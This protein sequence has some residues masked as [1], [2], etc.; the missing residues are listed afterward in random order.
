MPLNSIFLVTTSQVVMKNR[1]SYAFSGEYNLCRLI[2]ICT[3]GRLPNNV[4][5]YLPSQVYCVNKFDR[6]Q[7][8][9][10]LL[11]NR[12]TPVPLTEFMEHM[13]CKEATVKRL[14]SKFRYELGAPIIYD[15]SNNGYILENQGS[16]KYELPGLW[17]TIP[18]LH[19]LLIIQELLGT[20]QPGILSEDLAPFRARIKKI[21]STGAHKAESALGERLRIINITGRIVESRHFTECA[22]A[23]LRRRRLEVRY[24]SRSKDRFT[25]RIVSPQ[26]LIYYRDNWYLDC[27]CHQQ[28]DLRTFS[29][30]RFAKVR[31]LDERT[32]DIGADSLD[33]Y[34][35]SGYGIFGGKA[36]SWALLQF[37]PDRARWVADEHWHPDQHGEWSADGSYTLSLPY[38]DHRELVLD[39]M[40]F[41]PDVEVLSPPDL[42]EEV[43]RRLLQA[44]KKYE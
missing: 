1:F 16:T 42:R 25:D 2:N 28:K 11:C 10:N 37:T 29:L 38:T 35:T 31:P 27:W 23:T 3:S 26:R 9:H 32:K 7:Q 34:F 15:R 36:S 14:I 12:R 13:E 40:K 43:K 24:L 41:G 21:L 8:L 33:D 4:G 30:D 5:N 17:F 20:L 22:A 18:E 19:A 6:I 44:L 39:I